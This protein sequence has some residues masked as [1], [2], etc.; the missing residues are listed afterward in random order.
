MISWQRMVGST[1]N[2]CFSHPV[3]ADLRVR[4]EMD[5]LRVRL[6]RVRPD[7]GTASRENIRA[8]GVRQTHGRA[9]GQTH[10][11]M[12]GQT[13]RS[14]PT[15]VRVSA[16]NIRGEHRGS[17]L[18]RVVQWFKTMTTNEYVCGVKQYDWPPFPG[19]L[20]Q[21][22]YWEHIV[23]DESELNHFREYIGNNPS[24]W[25]MDKLFI[26]PDIRSPVLKTRGSRLHYSGVRRVFH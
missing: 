12:I 8:C 1:T 26:P 18:H 24:K 20:W 10:G 6:V 13:H 7:N 14:A 16:E 2:E 23:R 25:T 5:L 21:R 11:R 15:G 3:G 22:N 9:Q 4:P 19:K 17:P